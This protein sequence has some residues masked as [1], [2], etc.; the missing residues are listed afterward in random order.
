MLKWQNLI[1][2]KGSRHIVHSARA[3]HHALDRRELE[4]NTFMTMNGD[5]RGHVKVVDPR[6]C[7]NNSKH[8]DYSCKPNSQ[9]I[10]V[11]LGMDHDVL[12]IRVL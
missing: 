10:T 8:I 9:L 7:G 12:M 6:H 2:Y 3:L 5:E 11:S 1:E 4:S